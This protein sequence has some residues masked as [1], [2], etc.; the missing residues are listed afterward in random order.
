M[1]RILYGLPYSP[2]THRALFA[3]DHHREDYRFVEHLPLVGEWKL[4]RLSRHPHPTVPLFVTADGATMGGADIARRVDRDGSGTKLF[5]AAH[6]AEIDAWTERADALLSVARAQVLA[7]LRTSP[8]AQ[9]ESLPSF[10]PGPVRPLLR[11]VARQGID[12]IAKK[13]SVVGDVETRLRAEAG[14]IFE[15]LDAALLDHA[16]KPRDTILESFT[17]ADIAMATAISGFFPTSKEPGSNKLG[18]AT[19]ACWT[20][21][22]LVTKFPRAFAWRDRTYDAHRFPAR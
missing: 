5:P 15:T 7:A 14:P 9:E 11:I 1:P 16:G 19:R 2:W 10:V 6:H 13:H 18:P 3:L 12:F 21:E 20:R 17:F 8:R 22:D 4:R